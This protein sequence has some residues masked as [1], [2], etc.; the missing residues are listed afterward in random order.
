MT[1]EGHLP[2]SPDFTR[3]VIALFAAGV[4]TFALLYSTQAILPELAAAFGVTSDAATWTVSLTTIGLGATLLVAGPWSDATG[5]TRFIHGSLWLSSVI[6]LMAALAPSWPALLALRLAEGVALAGL[7]AVATAYLREELHGSVLARVAGMYIGGTAIGGMAGRLIT[8]PVAEHLGWRWALA[9]TAFV[10]LV[11]AAVVWRMLPGS[12]RFRPR[13]AGLR[14]LLQTTRR[15]LSDPVLLG[16]YTVGGVASGAIVGLFN[17]VGFRMAGA[18]FHL[19]LGAASLVFLVYPLGSA[20]SAIFGRLADRWGRR[21]VLPAG[22][23]FMAV[24]AVLTMA[25]SLP[26]LIGGVALMTIGFF[27]SHGIASGWVPA[28]AHARGTSAAQAA[29]LYLFSFYLGSSVFGT[30]AGHGWADAGWGGVVA[31]VCVLVAI[32]A[33]VSVALTRTRPAD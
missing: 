10:G 21:T 25:E 5:R 22:L 31:M 2:G 23:A 9:S 28:R 18:P 26:V 16:L 30:L 29:S 15:A 3:I 12:R 20:A 32:A 14:P 11:C 1:A 19:G 8:G 17:T 27:A 4:A 7:P 13:L 33:V 24:G 6:A